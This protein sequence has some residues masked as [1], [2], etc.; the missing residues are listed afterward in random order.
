MVWITE[1]ENT[2]P[3][4]KKVVTRQERRVI[5]R[6]GEALSPEERARIEADARRDVANARRDMAEADRD[7]AEAQREVRIARMEFRGKDG[8][9]PVRV[10]V[11]CDSDSKEPV[12]EWTDKDGKHVVS[13]CKAKIAA[14]ALDGLKEARKAIASDPNMPA[15]AR[16]AALDS[17]DAQIDRWSR[18]S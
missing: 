17:I 3:D 5:I 6:D 16:K 13:I 2:G 1:D 11:R 7:I 14:Q 15:D 8:E 9:P 10:E 4:G 18:D 12:R